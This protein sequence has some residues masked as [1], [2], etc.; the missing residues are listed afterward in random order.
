LICRHGASASTGP[1]RHDGD[2]SGKRTLKSGKIAYGGARPQVPTSVAI[3]DTFT[4]EAQGG[5]KGRPATVARR[6]VALIGV[7]FG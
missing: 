5:G 4:L 3:P 7:C 6:K 2:R 1:E